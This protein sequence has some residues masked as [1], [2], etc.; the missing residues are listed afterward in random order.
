[1][2]SQPPPLAPTPTISDGPTLKRRNAVLS[3]STSGLFPSSEEDDAV[4]DIVQSNPQL[5]S[6]AELSEP[7]EEP[8]S[9]EEYSVP[10]LPS[11]FSNFDLDEQK[12]IRICRAY[13]SLLVAQ[14]PPRAKRSK[15]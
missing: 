8:S 12:Q 10:D 15:K 3:A 13:A 11:Y 5:V 14:L 7:S 4:S 2:S 6:T 1:M 9:S